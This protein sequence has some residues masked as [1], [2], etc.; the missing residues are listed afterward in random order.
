MIGLLVLFAVQVVYALLA[1]WLFDFVLQSR[2]TGLTKHKDFKV[3]LRHALFY[4][5]SMTLA[6]AAW[7]GIDSTEDWHNL[8]QFQGVTFIS[9]LVTDYFTS[10]YN[11]KVYRQDDLKPLINGIGFDQWLH[12]AQLVFTILFIYYS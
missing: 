11:A 9:H 10:R 3:L 2:E 1:H 8:L 5:T 6:M 12:Q 7:S 4:S